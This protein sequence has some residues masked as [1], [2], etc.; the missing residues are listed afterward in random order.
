MNLGP[1]ETE[2][3]EQGTAPEETQSATGETNTEEEV[4]LPGEAECIE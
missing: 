1:K 4:E 2:Q 3:D